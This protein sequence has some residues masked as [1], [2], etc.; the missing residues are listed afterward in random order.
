MAERDLQ[1]KELVKRDP[2][3]QGCSI[4]ADIEYTGRTG[5]GLD[6]RVVQMASRS[7]DGILQLAPN[8]KDAP[9]LHFG[10][11]WSITFYSKEN[12]TVGRGQQPNNTRPTAIRS[13]LM[14]LL[15][16]SAIA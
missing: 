1:T 7:A 15:T 6:G 2:D 14:T 5:N 10:G 13:G 4:S 12:L 9:V 16:H 3:A 8:P 11:P